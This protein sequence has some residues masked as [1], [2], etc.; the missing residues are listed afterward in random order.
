MNYSDSSILKCGTRAREYGAQLD[1]SGEETRTR[2]EKRWKHE[3]I[4][5]FKLKEGALRKSLE[6]N[7]IYICTIYIYLGENDCKYRYWL[8]LEFGQYRHIGY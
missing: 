2:E 4:N 8:I 7:Y 1:E 5:N 6:Q 3:D